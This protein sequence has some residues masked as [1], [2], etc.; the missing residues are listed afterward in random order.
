MK[1][2]AIKYLTA[3]L[4]I[5]GGLLSCKEFETPVPTVS[6]FTIWE[7]TTDDNGS[8]VRGN[9]VTTVSVGEAVEV[10]VVGNADIATLW[11]GDFTYRPW[12]SDSILDSRLYEHYG[13]LGAQGMRMNPTQD[14]FVLQYFW[15][16][17]GTYDIVL[18]LTSH[19]IDG[20][21]FEQR[22]FDFTVDVVE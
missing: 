7:L 17:T 22:E 9:P 1:N 16:E 6:N 8:V 3:F 15:P 11:P 4:L 2:F 13:Q 21:T 12:E 18:V 20:P 14:G 5:S 10:E 19:G